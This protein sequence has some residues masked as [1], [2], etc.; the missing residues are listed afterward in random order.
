MLFQRKT[1]RAMKWSRDRRLRAEG[2]DPEQED[3]QREI[4]NRKKGG[5]QDDLPTMEELM[6][7]EQTL[8][9]EKGDLP[10]IILAAMTTIVPVCLL[11]LIV[12]CLAA[13]LFI[14]GW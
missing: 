13:Y 2:R 6:K 3:L 9:L 7:E 11:V 12:I 4:E 5:H 1:R 14:F 10:A 8:Q